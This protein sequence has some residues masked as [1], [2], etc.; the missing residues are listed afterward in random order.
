MKR[1]TRK[2]SNLLWLSRFPPCANDTR[3]RRE[4]A[5]EQR[6][7]HTDPRLLYRR[8]GRWQEAYAQFER[9]TELNPQDLTGYYSAATLPADF[10]GG[11]K[12]IAS[13]HA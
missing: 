11:M 13:V 1:Y 6:R 10:A 7:S 3:A 5:A 8:F 9:A 12:L 2:P 4:G